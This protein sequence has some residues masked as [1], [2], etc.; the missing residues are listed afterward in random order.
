MMTGPTR[1]ALVE[2]LSPAR[3]KVQFTASAELHDKL[4]RLQALMRSEV[5]GGDLAAIIERAVTE[6][7]ER[8]EASPASVEMSPN[9]S[10]SD[11][12]GQAIRPPV[13][14]LEDELP[15]PGFGRSR[16]PIEPST[17]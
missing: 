9:E 1:Q 17:S 10:G 5:P 16:G 13:G 15:G 12:Q 11:F 6:K 2:P 3:Y 7:L 14:W 8:L 4:E